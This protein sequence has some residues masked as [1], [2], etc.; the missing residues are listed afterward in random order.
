MD[1][2]GYV[3]KIAKKETTECNIL[4]MMGSNGEHIDGYLLEKGKG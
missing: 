4:L 3:S 1:A 2:E